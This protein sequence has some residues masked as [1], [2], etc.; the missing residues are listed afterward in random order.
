MTPA[1]TLVQAVQERRAELRRY[2]DWFGTD[3]VGRDWMTGPA[4]VAEYRVRLDELDRLLLFAN[5]AEVTEGAPSRQCPADYLGAPGC[6]CKRDDLHE[7][8]AIR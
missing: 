3:P 1:E 4:S 7:Y 6:I 8:A 5:V 2:L